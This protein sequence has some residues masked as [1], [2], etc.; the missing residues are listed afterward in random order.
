VAASFSLFGVDVGATIIN[1][2]GIPMNLIGTAAAPIDPLLGRLDDNGGPTK[3]HALLPGS[4][5]I[6]AG[7]PATMIGGSVPSSD[8]RGAPH[9][10]LEDG[11]NAGGPR[12][13]IGAVE[14]GRSLP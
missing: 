9:S 13:D 2:C 12:I 14:A 1:S 10:R 4:P 7:D 6:D 5:A 8:Q 3:T 11:D